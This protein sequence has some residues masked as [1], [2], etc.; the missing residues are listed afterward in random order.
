MGK[1]RRWYPPEF[2]EPMIE[3]VRSERSA[4]ELA[5]EFEPTKQSI[6]NWVRQADRD[7]GRPSDGM[8]TDERTELRRLQRENRR[9]KIARS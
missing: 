4:A 7:T 3:Q 1:S 9:E 5:S 6:L 8:T 2:R